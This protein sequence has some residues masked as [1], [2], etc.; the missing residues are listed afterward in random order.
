MLAK[1]D[2]MNKLFKVNENFVAW[3]ILIGWSIVHVICILSFLAIIISNKS[4]AVKLLLFFYALMS[5][6]YVFDAYLAM[7]KL[8]DKK[9][10][11]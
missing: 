5:F 3:Y 10:K 11:K 8:K 1:T 6:L 7:K 4:I 9:Q 2:R